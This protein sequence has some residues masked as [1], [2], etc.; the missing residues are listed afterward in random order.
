MT[1][2]TMELGEVLVLGVKGSG[3]TVFLSVLGHQYEGVGLFGLSLSP[4]RRTWKWAYDYYQA[5]SPEDGLQQEFP[6]ATDPKNNPVPL[7]WKVRLGTEPLFRM[8]TLECAGETMVKAFGEA[9]NAAAENE[10]SEA[11]TA[12]FDAMDAGNGA[13]LTAE[14]DPVTKLRVLAKRAK[15]I[16]LF[17][18]PRDFESQLA[19]LPEWHAAR[20]EKKLERLRAEGAGAEALKKAR[21]LNARA[22]SEARAGLKGR[23]GDMLDLL[24]TFLEND[25]YR[26]KRLVFVLTQSGGLQRSIEEMGGAWGFLQSNVRQ[27][28]TYDLRDRSE[29]LAVSA[30]NNTELIE[31]EDGLER[32][33][34][35]GPIES[36]GLEDFLLTVGGAC[37]QKLAGLKKAR[38]ECLDAELRFTEN[39]LDGG[40]ADE[41]WK[42]ARQWFDAALA[43]NA[44]VSTFIDGLENVRVGVKQ[45]T[46]TFAKDDLDRAERRWLAENALHARLAEDVAAGTEPPA[47]I[48]AWLEVANEAVRG[49]RMTPWTLDELDLD[50]GWVGEMVSARKAAWSR[51]KR[52]FDGAIGRL[53]CEEAEAIL[54]E[55]DLD[56]TG[57]AHRKLE[58]AVENARQDKKRAAEEAQ[59]AAELA[60]AEKTR[61]RLE[62]ECR[63]ALEEEE[64]ATAE[65]KLRDM[66]EA[67]KTAG[68]SSARPV[69]EQGVACLKVRYKVLEDLRPV[70]R[71]L[72]NL[73]AGSSGFDAA[74]ER[75]GQALSRAEQ[76]LEKGEN[77][78]GKEN[79]Q[80]LRAS[81]NAWKKRMEALK[82]A[83]GHRR[84]AKWV[85]A[86]LAVA[87]PLAAWMAGRNQAMKTMEAAKR[88]V[89]DLVKE[90]QFEAAQKELE[91]L[92]DHPLFG[93]R[94]ADYAPRELWTCLDNAAEM[95][96]NREGLKKKRTYMERAYGGQGEKVAG[97]AWI[98]SGEVLKTATAI[99]VP[100]KEGQYEWENLPL[101][102]ERYGAAAQKC[103]LA[104]ESLKTA[105]TGAAKDTTEFA[106]VLKRLEEER[107]RQDKTCKEL[108]KATLD[109][110]IDLASLPEWK[111]WD[112]A[113]NEARRELPIQEGKPNL[114]SS[115][116]SMLAT[117]YKNALDNADGLEKKAQTALHALEGA[118]D[119][120]IQWALV[121][122]QANG[123][124]IQDW[125]AAERCAK[126]FL[127]SGKGQDALEEGWNAVLKAGKASRKPGKDEWA[128]LEGSLAK[129]DKEATGPERQALAAAQ[130][131]VCKAAAAYFA[132]K[133]RCEESARRQ[134]NAEKV[135]SAVRDAYNTAETADALAAQLK[136]LG[137]GG[138]SSRTVSKALEII[139]GRKYPEEA[140]QIFD[141]KRFLRD[142]RVLKELG[143]E[144]CRETVNK[145]V[146]GW[147]QPWVARARTETT[148]SLAAIGKSDFASAWIHCTN[149]EKA[150]S[151]MVL[152]LKCY[153]DAEKT[154]EMKG[155]LAE[156]RN[157]LPIL[158]LVRG[159]T[160]ISTYECNGRS[161]S[162]VTPAEEPNKVAV[163]AGERLGQIQSVGLRS[164]SG[165]EKMV[166]VQFQRRGTQATEIDF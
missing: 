147:N 99:P 88:N 94:K 138:P 143:M 146:W 6:P 74:M 28:E 159:D 38:R 56:E 36:A 25:D 158:M 131:T 100:I 112:D 164:A 41:R 162:G 144:E 72:N 29:A 157:R 7:T 27:L 102:S 142:H 141:A 4:D 44:E 55:A 92:G 124:S 116:H 49:H 111:T 20:L 47:D 127:G 59:R 64:L 5:M 35:C 60:E 37:S 139:V 91:K 30:V 15:V 21:M 67:E 33:H 22:L 85:A 126:K 121:Q 73:R 161:Y 51:L 128:K 26:E 106:S 75:A 11:M 8:N 107:T 23:Y 96:R 125:K 84:K 97:I 10:Y 151:N 166:T 123:M 132:E 156:S 48:P 18:N 93:V 76:R 46:Q 34:P 14:A 154:K 98:E 160:D 137:F 109:W 103:K 57:A 133:E 130:E 101:A 54:R 19:A 87:I 1:K 89:M 129:A 66:E 115:E 45:R 145:R 122:N 83:R 61:S 136:V 79:F 149:A 63:A 105:E 24:R 16:C 120:E 2:R 78:Y 150:L 69:L 9:G 50:E 81:I 117:K 31:G 95:A 90:E 68:R 135:L 108:G 152:W 42:S 118:V 71:L 114:P 165:R 70:P 17:L 104:L 32:E 86:A 52:R 12:A 39:L 62:A 80:D 53:D 77:D 110:K 43:W 65:T 58:E 134:Q 153:K 40:T 119:R 155:V 82:L 163:L 13:G 113:K 140:P 148:A 3:K